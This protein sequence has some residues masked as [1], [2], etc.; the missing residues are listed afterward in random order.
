V[1][2][3]QAARGDQRVLAWRI[4][5]LQAFLRF[6]RSAAAVLSWE[7]GSRIRRASILC[8]AV[9]RWIASYIPERRGFGQLAARRLGDRLADTSAQLSRRG[10]QPHNVVRPASI[11]VDRS[12]QRSRRG[13]RA[14]FIALVLATSPARGMAIVILGD[15][16]TLCRNVVGGV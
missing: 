10:A 11:T 15:L 12:R 7:S 1:I 5:H 2:Q 4:A 8:R 3:H 14:D 16:E 13:R 9:A 6:N